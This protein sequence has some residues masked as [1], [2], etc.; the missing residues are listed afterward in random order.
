MKIFLMV[1]LLVL[2]SCASI[3]S[4]S[5]IDCDDD[6]LACRESAT[7]EKLPSTYELKKQGQEDENST[8]YIN[9]MGKS[10][11]NK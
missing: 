9:N 5:R 2:S 7:V 4:Y 11:D 6:Q 1:G 10:N 8:V 3:P